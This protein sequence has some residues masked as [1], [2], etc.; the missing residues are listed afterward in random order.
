MIGDYGAIR[1]R[2]KE[3]NAAN[4]A[5]RNSLKGGRLGPYGSWGEPSTSRWQVLPYSSGTKQTLPRSRRHPRR[6]FWPS[7]VRTWG[8]VDV[9]DVDS[10]E[11]RGCFYHKSGGQG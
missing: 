1:E 11:I 7:G 5:P 4:T 8:V 10:G 3:K 6:W 9:A 2:K